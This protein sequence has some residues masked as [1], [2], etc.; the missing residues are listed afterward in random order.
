M[1]HDQALPTTL[2]QLPP[3]AITWLLGGGLALVTAAQFVTMVP[4]MVGVGLLMLGSTLAIPQRVPLQLRLLATTTNVLVY[5]LLYGLFAG[6]TMHHATL[7][8]P[9]APPWFR[10]T[11]LGSSLWLVILSL[12]V[13]VRQIQALL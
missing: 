4:V 3:S 6:A 13:G 7:W 5:L 12:Q 11:D 9:V 10:L 8:M 2:Q 1:N